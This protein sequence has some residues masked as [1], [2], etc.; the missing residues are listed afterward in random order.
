MKNSWNKNDFTDNMHARYEL[1]KFQI[2]KFCRNKNKLK[3]QLRSNE[4]G[5][6]D[7]LDKMYK[8]IENMDMTDDEMKKKL[9]NSN[10]NMT[11]TKITV[12]E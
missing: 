12:L 2:I 8:K 3:K 5:L 1:V 11:C 9:T 7:K 6:V 4:S 10:K